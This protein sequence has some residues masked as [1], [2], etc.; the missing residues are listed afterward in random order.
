MQKFWAMQKQELFNALDC[1][2]SGLVSQ[3]AV[4]R[5]KKFGLNEFPAT[6]KRN[7]LSI[8]VS[9]FKSPFILILVVAAIIAF[10]LG[11]Q[12]DALIILAMVVLNSFLGFFQ[13]F[14]SEQALQKLRKLVSFNAKVLR[15]K[16][17]TEISVKELV[18]G[19]TIFL[20]IGDIVPADCRILSAEEF[21]CNESA[22]TGEAEPAIKT[23]SVLSLEKPVLFE[24]KNMAFM[25]TNVASGNAVLL[26]V[27]TGY[28][29]EL[30]KTAEFLKE[31]NSASNFEKSLSRFGRFLI[32]VIV[33]LT[34]FIFVVNSFFGKG[35]LESFLFA[36]AL[37]VGITPEALPIIIT[38]GLSHGAMELSKKKVVVKKLSS[39]EDLG[40]IDVLCSDKTGT[41]TENNF[42]LDSFFDAEGKKSEEI[43][44]YSLLCNSAVKT[45]KKFVGNS[46]D[47]AIKEFAEKHFDQKKLSA[48]EKVEEIGFDFGRRRQSVIVNSRQGL[49]LICKG[50][51]DSLLKQCNSVNISGNS[52]PIAAKKDLLEKRFEELSNQGYRV[53]AVAAKPIEQKKGFV[54]ADETGLCFFGFVS[55]FD[56]PK[57][58]AAESIRSLQ[59]L[60]VALKIITGDN[61]LV[62]REVCR[63]VKFQIVEDKI[64]D[65]STLA[66]ISEMQA[67]ES[68][69]KFNVFV[70]VSPEQKLQIVKA[71]K[72][73]GHIVGFL[74]DGINDADALKEADVGI[75][76][77]SAV[78]IAR[79]SADII[80]L[81]KSLLVIDDGIKEG[82][83]IFGNMI[84]YI[85]NTVSANF[86]NMATLAVSSIF[87]PFIPLLPTQI[88]LNNFLSDGPMLMIST[89]NVDKEYLHKPKRW[90]ISAIKNFMFFFGFL[91]SVFDLLT[92]IF[93]LFVLKA[94]T[95]LFRT[96]WFLESVLSEILVTFA[97]RTKRPFWKSNPSKWLLASSI[98]V[99]LLSVAII[100]APF[101]FLFAF[102]PLPLWFLA[103]IFL[104]LL[105]YFCLA[106]I[107]KGFFFKHFEM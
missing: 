83:R 30:G 95:E 62:T 42:S 24:L 48:F 65:G 26:V 105:A 39:V 101:N 53:I 66:G 20:E 52:F 15:D 16:A 106:E 84:K 104:I 40:N 69:K 90:S 44:L 11:E 102:V 2:E 38:I 74:G 73:Q 8:L 6:K 10:F 13:E 81:N 19:D 98:I 107:A 80:L 100:Y 4:S 1:S 68:I 59:S 12:T 47:V 97:I 94:N 46:I 27:S 82:R 50:S 18:P 75:T 89:D 79:E 51:F 60:G 45:K 64:I 71:L 36:L 76:V 85:L 77:D 103:I 23:S 91:S 61:A 43:L 29:T 31:E 55:F 21:S 92:I 70:R 7:A 37:A 57:K 56:P 25:G 88:L 67:F 14:K 41:L 58:Q 33:A 34:F 86:G 96:G 17:E 54:V 32:Y 63:Q 35:L 5:L 72:D 28:G 87:L 99:F 9:Q 3:E 78:D 93:L 22:L 49:L